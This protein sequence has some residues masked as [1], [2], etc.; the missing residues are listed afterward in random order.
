MKSKSKVM[1]IME[2]FLVENAVQLFEPTKEGV[3]TFA[4]EIKSGIDNLVPE[5]RLHTGTFGHFDYLYVK[6]IL[7]PKEKWPHNIADNAASMTFYFTPD[8]KMSMPNDHLYV[9]SKRPNY[10]LDR[11]P[12]KFVKQSVKD[13]PTAIS[14]IKKMID[15]AT[16]AYE[17]AGEPLNQ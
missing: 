11:L 2:K 6:V 1:L 8:G 7:Q 14:K 16:A 15:A 13:A 3:T 12:I 5:V 10:A 17:A 9:K 4:N